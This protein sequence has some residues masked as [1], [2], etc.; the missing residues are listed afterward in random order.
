MSSE[1]T[2]TAK[3]ALSLYGTFFRVGLFMFGGGYAMLP[4]LEKECVEKQGWTDREEL[5]DVFALAQCTPGIIAVNTATYIGKKQGGL[6][7]SAAATLGVI[8]PS[9]ILISLIAALLSNF[10]DIPAVQHAL[11][12]IRAV[13]TALIFASVFKM[14]K[15]A[16][17]HPVQVV[18]MLL[19]FLA[20]AL[21]GASPV[22]TVVAAALI[23]YLYF[24]VLAARKE[25]DA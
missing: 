19:A 2:S 18:I 3:T 25:G 21:F 20:V 12:G 1:S 8:T 16:L 7:G 10:A 6:L 17:K 4:L 5:L 11:A 14:G 23:G 9:L 24:G 13:V 22:I 15:S